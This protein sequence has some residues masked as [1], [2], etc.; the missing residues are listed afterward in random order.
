[1]PVML[2]GETFMRDASQLTGALPWLP[3]RSSTLSWGMVRS[4]LAQYSAPAVSTRNTVVSMSDTVLIGCAAV[5]IRGPSHCFGPPRLLADMRY[6]HSSAANDKKA[7]IRS[8]LEY[9]GLPYL[10][11]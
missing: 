1:M 11:P 6:A 5:V 2:G 9:A 7:E 4:T 8:C 10:S 3:R